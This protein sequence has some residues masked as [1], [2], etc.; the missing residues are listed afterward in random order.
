MVSVPTRS[1]ALLTPV[2]FLLVTVIVKVLVPPGWI[3]AGLT[4]LAMVTSGSTTR[5]LSGVLDA[6]MTPPVEEWSVSVA[7]LVTLSLRW[8]PATLATRVE[9]TTLTT[10]SVDVMF[11]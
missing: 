2:G 11:G 8:L 9:K 1:K 6:V 4:V 7:T 3:L 10:S 5:V